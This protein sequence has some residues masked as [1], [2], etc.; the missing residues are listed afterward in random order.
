MTAALVVVCG[1]LGAAVGWA[2]DP[3]IVRVPR[4]VPL[5]GPAPDLPET[6]TKSRVLVAV[7]CGAIAAGLAA[8][9]DDTWVLPA[10]LVVGVTLVVLS[11]IDLQHYLLPNR[12]V[13]PLSGATVALLAFAGLADGDG[14]A[15]VRALLAGVVAFVAFFVLHLVVPSGL[16]FGD[17]KL[18]FTLGAA[19]GWLG[20]GEVAFGLFLGFLYGAVLGIGL[21]VT[22]LRSRKDAVPFGPFLALGT[23][24]VLFLGPALVDWYRA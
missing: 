21:I 9:W 10:Y 24:T 12:I 6:S 22:G 20:W 23:L 11:V 17:V 16:G 3:V 2:A 1:V 18:A 13:Y 4:K 19:M 7:L 8:R 5:G 15:L 14:D